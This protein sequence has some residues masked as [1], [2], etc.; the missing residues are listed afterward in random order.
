MNS[1]NI[2]HDLDRL[3]RKLNYFRSEVIINS[4]P[5]I[6]FELRER[7]EFLEKQIQNQKNFIANSPTSQGSY[8]ILDELLQTDFQA[9][10]WQLFESLI[11][12]FINYTQNLTKNY[13]LSTPKNSTQCIGREKELH[14]IQTFLQGNKPQ[15][16][17][18]YGESGLGKSAIVEHFWREN[19]YQYS[20]LVWLDCQNGIFN[21]ML[22]LLIPELNKIPELHFD[23]KEISD[24]QDYAQVR[25]ALFNLKGQNAQSPCLMVLDNVKDYTELN[26]F[27]DHFRT[28]D[29]QILITVREYPEFGIFYKNRLKINSLSQENAKELFARYSEKALSELDTLSLHFVSQML[30]KVRYNTFCICLFAKH[31][32]QYSFEELT[33]IL[34]QRKINIQHED[35]FLRFLYEASPFLEIDEQI[36]LTQLALFP[37][38][39]HA[40]N[41][42]SEVFTPENEAD[43]YQKLDNLA[44]KGWLQTTAEIEDKTENK[45]FALS[46][47]GQQII[48]ETHQENI[49]KYTKNLLTNLSDLLDEDDKTD[50][51]IIEI[52]Q[53]YAPLADAV[54]V[55]FSRL[56]RNLSEE[57]YHL[58]QDLI[59]FREQVLFLKSEIELS[60]IS[61]KTFIE[62]E[63]QGQPKAELKEVYDMFVTVCRKL[64]KLEDAY[65]YQKVL[66]EICR[67]NEPEN[68]QGLV[69]ALDR[70]AK[71]TRHLGLYVESYH[72]YEEEGQILHSLQVHITEIARWQND[73]AIVLGYL[74]KLNEAKILLEHS[75]NVAIKYQN[76][77]SLVIANRQSNLANTLRELKGD[78]NLKKAVLLLKNTVKIESQYYSK[79]HPNLI[80]NKSNLA[81]TIQN[82]GG[83]DNLMI[84]KDILEELLNSCISNFSESHPKTA[85]RQFNL[86]TVYHQLGGTNN[87]YQAK[88]FYKKAYYTYK[89][90]YTYSHPFTKSIASHLFALF[91]ILKKGKSSENFTPEEKQRFGK[92]FWKW[93]DEEEV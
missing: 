69:S 5:E 47:K 46:P 44:E 11:H 2:H 43:F 68:K 37:A 25:T 74:K 57:A 84:A 26:T 33:Q 39:F 3:I 89:N 22:S 18:L 77:D 88:H 13:F 91:F 51:E 80:T 48:L 67:T 72:Y 38:D 56:A 83:F 45:S 78:V 61:L 12:K 6:K 21:K 32:K 52:I 23:L 62:Q 49:T 31:F 41:L 73:I 7:I 14:Q 29:W 17:V 60:Y 35:D 92:E 70:I 24:N 8:S 85:I 36:L 53:V 79:N 4:S 19:Q 30:E 87:L 90:V 65:K 64:F 50:D 81:I 42:L 58:L 76:D 1:H 66:L 86:G 59:Y 15:H 82:L 20:Y 9:N 93:V 40:K 34:S 63:E 27:Y 54:L 28:L 71:I 16:L 55:N 10:Q 75:L